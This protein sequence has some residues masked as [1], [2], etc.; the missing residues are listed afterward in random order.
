MEMR[1]FIINAQKYIDTKSMA[2][3]EIVFKKF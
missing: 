1:H 3:K 2:E